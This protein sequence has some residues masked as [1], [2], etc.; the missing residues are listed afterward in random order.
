MKN[1]EKKEVL[2]V[3]KAESLEGV[4]EISGAKNSALPNI[5]STILTDKPVILQ[6]LPELL[7]VKY[8]NSLLKAIGSK[9]EQIDEKT[10]VYSLKEPTSLCV[11][12]EIVNKMRASILVLGAMLS[13]FG[14]AKIALPGGCPIGQRP[15][16]LHIK[17]LRKMGV[18]IDIEHGFVIAKGRPKGSHITFDKITVTGTENIL[19]ASVLAE[20]ETIIENA[21]LEPEVVDLANLLKKMGA[22]IEWNWREGSRT[23]KIRG[24]Q[25]LKGT[26]HKIIPDRIEAGTFAIMSALTKSKIILKNYPYNL[27]TYVH[28]IL[29]K[30][31]I[32]IIKTGNDT[33]IVKREKYLKPT[34]IETKEY[35]FFPTD[36]QAQ[37]MTLLSTIDGLSL[38]K[39]NIFENRFLH[40]PELIR[41][42]ACI[43]TINNKVA[44]I[45]GVKNLSGANVKA[46]DLRASAAMVIAG[47]IAEGYTT[48]H[49]LHHLD[50]GYEKIDLKLSSLGA[51][52]ER[53]AVPIKENM[54]E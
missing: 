3:H 29:N 5:A 44:I 33:V 15:I 6:N 18:S 1:K 24:V 13:R 35:P 32:H 41:L 54:F 7:D 21:A 38:I 30:I 23:I 52:I 28:S 51:N 31:G 37:V 49:N 2:I 10:F 43:S 50:R 46:T 39:E 19:M 9:V 12:Y 22:D 48:I 36:L 16:D 34:Y 14:E 11:D 8:M 26:A 27:L 4:L 20:G 42:G 40:V 17:A 25:K 45:N 47:L 53:K